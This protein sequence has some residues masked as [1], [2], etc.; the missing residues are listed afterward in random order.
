MLKV[1]QPADELSVCVRACVRVGMCMF[2][3]AAGEPH[4]HISTFD[5]A[6]ITLRRSLCLCFIMLHEQKKWRLFIFLLLTVIFI[7]SYVCVSRDG[8]SSFAIK[9]NCYCL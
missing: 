3:A 7:I 4:K 9:E 1:T 8:P 2:V 6:N 5:G